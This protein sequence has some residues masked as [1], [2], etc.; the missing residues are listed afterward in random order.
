MVVIA[1]S[2]PVLDLAAR[3]ARD[4]PVCAVGEG[5]VPAGLARARGDQVGGARRAVEHL[6]AT[7][8]SRIAH[9]A[10]RKVAGDAPGD[11]ARDQG[12]ACAERDESHGDPEREGET[13]DQRVGVVDSAAR[14]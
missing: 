6:R 4:L 11:P 12:S 7:G 10:G 3:F 1:W 13:A 9:L 5:D 14:L 2:Q 8:R